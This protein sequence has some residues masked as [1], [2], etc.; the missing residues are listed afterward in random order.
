MLF[1][2]LRIIPM[3]LSFILGGFM[4]SKIGGTFSS[5]IIMVIFMLLKT[6][7]DTFTHAV[8]R[9]DFGDKASHSAMHQA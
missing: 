3:H 6:F 1:S 4:V 7:A 9:R 5:K 2:Y 8:E